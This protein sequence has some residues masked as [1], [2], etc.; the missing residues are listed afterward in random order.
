M[1]KSITYK[2]V[3]I[4]VL[5]ALLFSS[6]APAVEIAV[7]QP[8]ANGITSPT[9]GA[10][11]RG[12][13]S[14]QGVATHPDFRKWQLDLL[15]GG[16]ADQATFLALGEAPVPAP[17]ELSVFDTTAYPD[18]QHTLRLR[19]VRGDTNYDEYFTDILIA[20]QIP[21]DAPAPVL[22][23][24]APANGAAWDGGPGD[25]HLRQAAGRRADPGQPGAGGRNERRWRG[26]PLHTGQPAGERRPLPLHR[27]RR[28]RGGRHSPRQ[29]ADHRAQRSRRGRRRR[30]PARRRRRGCRRQRAHRGALQP[31]HGAAHGH[32]RTGRP[33]AAADLRPAG[34]GRRR[35]D[36][37]QRLPLHPGAAAGRCDDLPRGRG[38]AARRCGPEQFRGLQLLLHH[39]RAD[40]A[41]RQTHRHLC[42]A[43][44]DGQ[45]DLQPAYGP[46]EH[47]SRLQPGRPG[48]GRDRR[49]ARRVSRAGECQPAGAR[50]DRLRRWRA[51]SPGT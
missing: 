17:A 11:L 31:P 47:G 23:A 12:A 45:R 24:T 16:N 19:V 40:R 39:R 1:T 46:G 7:A 10:I 21:V 41:Q 29:R 25:L 35:V 9:A 44:C 43:G 42:D 49:H 18:G 14:V 51:V 3:I 5:L 20:N 27:G 48:R 50:G 33:A 37:H 34:G 28:R 38:R 4:L 32:C 13:V 15:P 6:V 22:L 30:H 36:Q 2:P 26:C 8:A